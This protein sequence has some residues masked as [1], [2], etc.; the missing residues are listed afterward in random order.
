M[1]KVA[2]CFLLFIEA[3][4]TPGQ[5]QA[6]FPEDRS[7]TIRKKL[8]AQ[9]TRFPAVIDSRGRI[10][11]PPPREN[12]PGLLTGMAVSPGVVIGPVKILLSP[13]EKGLEKGDVLVAYTTDP[14]WTPLFVNAS[15][16][17]LE[18]GGALQHGAV[19]AR[20][21]GKPCVVG[22]D[23]V[24]AKLRDGALV[25]VNGTMGTVRLLS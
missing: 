22:I 17:V 1:T 18:V 12:T 15:A 23:Q 21:F 2:I 10:L 7:F 14:G 5:G 16:I 6:F 25:E 20:E 19:V 4:P 9:V 8:D 11:R 3:M 24:V 13:Y